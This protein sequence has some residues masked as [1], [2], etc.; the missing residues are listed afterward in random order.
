ML[1]GKPLQVADTADIPA[2]YRSHQHANNIVQEALESV[3][4]SDGGEGTIQTV[5]LS[6]QISIIVLPLRD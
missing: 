5:E 4:R 1:F 3:E 6:K 2:P